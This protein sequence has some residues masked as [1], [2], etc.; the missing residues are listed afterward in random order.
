MGKYDPLRT[1]LRSQSSAAVQLSFKQIEKIIAAPLPASAS[2]A[3]WWI[4]PQGAIPARRQT[5][6][7]RSAG[8]DAQLRSGLR[9]KFT[10]MK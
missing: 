5:L 3:R 9:V 7:W 4:G 10:R 1:F 8:Y 2:E 6:A